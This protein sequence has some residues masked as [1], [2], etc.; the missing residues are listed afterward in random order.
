M[1]QLNIIYSVF[2]GI[3][4]CF[5]DFCL[6]QK[7]VS[8]STYFYTSLNNNVVEGLLSNFSHQFTS[9]SGTINPD[10]EV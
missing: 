9:S 4:Y 6:M 10:F 1:Q 3:F 7:S 5:L 8:H 2:S